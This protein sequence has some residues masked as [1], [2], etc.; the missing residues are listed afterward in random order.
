MT[1]E[2]DRDE[3]P[4]DENGQEDPAVETPEEMQ[5]G[6]TAGERA[7][8]VADG[9]TGE[10]IEWADEDDA[11]IEWA[12]REGGPGEGL[13]WA[14]NGDDVDVGAFPAATDDAA[15]G[16]ADQDGDAPLPDQSS[17]DDPDAADDEMEE[18]FEDMVDDVEADEVWAEVTDE[19]GDG[20][21][22]ETGE[23]AP[24]ERPVDTDVAEVSKHDYCESCEYFS[25]APEIHC[26]HDGT[27]ILDFVDMDK[28]RVS[29][30]PIVAEREGLEQGVA[31][32]STDLGAMERE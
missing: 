16:T 8:E 22:A 29:D 2:T 12:E 10:S 6:D 13:S 25:E 32:G 26:T 15:S 9:D 24:A 27:E 23:T 28:V 17:G 31:K 30:C 4:P 20:T 18:A 1:D 7:D 19:D 14:D 5:W 11:D 3:E 21:L